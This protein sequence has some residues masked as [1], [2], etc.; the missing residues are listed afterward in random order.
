MASTMQIAISQEQGRGPITIFQVQGDLDAHSSEELQ[1][2]AEEAHQAGMRNLLLDLTNVKYISSVGL[3]AFYHIFEMLREAS[4]ENDEAMK[5]GLL[6]GS[7]KSAHFKLLNP[8][9]DVANILK[10][11]GFDMF[12]EIHTNRQKALASF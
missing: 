10:M 9:R 5:R 2:R 3:Q 7:Y 12:L 8:S 4:P 6:D 11:S 1:A